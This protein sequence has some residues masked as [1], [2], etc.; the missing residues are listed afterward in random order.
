MLVVKNLVKFL[1]ERQILHNINFCLKKGEIIALLGPNGSGKTTLMR[2]ICGFYE[3][4]AGEI[5]FNGKTIENGR[6]EF[7]QDMA[8]VPES[9]GIYPE[10]S[11]C[12]YLM[13]VAK[14]RHIDKEK[15]TDNLVYLAKAL[16]LESVIN[17]RC[18]TLSKGY[19]RRVALAGAMIA[20]PKLLVLDEPTEGLDPLQKQHLRDFLK[21]YGKDNTVLVSTH[22]MEEVEMLAE[23]V[24]MIKNGRLICDTTTEEMKK[25]SAESSVEDY[26]CTMVRD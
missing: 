14:L 12:E 4:D 20:R 8:Y 10:M 13:F 1:G 9:G 7:L 19:K 11:V 6:C 21:N 26:F 23:R 3:I 18:E 24:L 17:Q 22:I 5:R 16:D 15:F 2:C 25:L